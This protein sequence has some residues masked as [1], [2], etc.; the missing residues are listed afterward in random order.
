MAWDVRSSSGNPSRYVP[1]N[2][3]VATVRK[4]EC[5][6]QGCPSCAK[7]DMQRAEYRK[8]M[9]ILEAAYG[10]FEWQSKTPTML[11]FQFHII[12]GTDD[13]TNLETNDLRSHD[14][15]GEFAIQTKVSW[16]KNITEER[17]CP[18]QVLIGAADTNFC[19]LLALACYLG[20]RLK[21][22]QNGRYLFGDRDDEFEP[23]RANERYCRTLRQCWSDPEFLELMAKV[24]GSLGSHS[25]HKFPGTWCAENGSSDPEV[26]IRGRWKGNKNG[27][28]VNRYISVEQ[29]STDAKLAGILAVGGPVRYKLKADS[30][31]SNSFLQGIVTPKTHEHLGADQSNTI[32]DVLALPLLWAC[33][34]PTLAHVV[35]PAVQLRIQKGYNS[36][37]GANPET[38]NPVIKVPL[39]I[40]RVENQVF[41]QDTIA[42]GDQ[43]AV[44]EG[45]HPATASV[46]SGQLQTI[47]LS[48]NRLDQQQA[49]HHQQQQTHMSELRNYTATQFKITNSNVPKCAMQPSRR[50]GASRPA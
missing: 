22:N 43:P 24:K 13:I 14:T 48:I 16:S 25:N 4:L 10:N 36:I 20:S 32:A 39:H 19:I 18:G 30:H 3:T 8:T 7:R 2:N 21:T 42:L 11:K 27:R 31:V 29:L 17:A 41:I 15:F 23:D 49:E 1:V 46:Q 6:K 33:H 26:G 47:L 35:A 37:R 50:I 38:Y 45:A 44:S 9:H 5:R 12:A 40:S 34:E 28:V